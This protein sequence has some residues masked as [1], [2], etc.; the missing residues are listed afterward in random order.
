M[1]QITG[2]LPR[3]PLGLRNVGQQF[4]LSSHKSYLLAPHFGYLS[5]L[6]G[7]HQRL[8]VQRQVSSLPSLNHITP[9]LNLTHPRL[10]RYCD[11][12]LS[13]RYLSTISPGLEIGIPPDR[14]DV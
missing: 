11:I 6:S 8:R 5:R 2:S 4:S 14:Q 9:H 1:F 10:D 12:D 7:R 3:L 13:Q